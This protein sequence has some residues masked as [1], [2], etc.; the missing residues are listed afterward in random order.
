MI[1]NESFFDD[2]DNDSIEKNDNNPFED[3]TQKQESE[4]TIKFW[5]N[6][7]AIS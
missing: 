5:F 6:K 1:L 3:N 2:V 4:Y 7:I